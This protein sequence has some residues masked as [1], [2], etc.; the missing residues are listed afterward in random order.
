MPSL[1]RVA[2]EKLLMEEKSGKA[3]PARLP[4]SRARRLIL[5]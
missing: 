1:E 3:D 4:K 2:F 5:F